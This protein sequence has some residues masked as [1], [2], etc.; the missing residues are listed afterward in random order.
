LARRR[1]AEEIGEEAPRPNTRANI[2]VTKLLTF[3]GGANKV[4]GFLMTCKLYI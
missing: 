4:S 1:K 2:D 3:N